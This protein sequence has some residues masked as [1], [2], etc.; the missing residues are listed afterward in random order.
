MDIVLK[1]ENI[2]N[3]VSAEMTLPFSKG[4]YA[5][6]G[7]NGCGKSTIMLAMSLMVKTSSAH[8]L[9]G[10]AV[11][12]NSII[13]IEAD[14]RADKWTYNQKRK[15]L[16]TGKFHKRNGRLQMIASAHFEGFYEGSIF[17]GCRFDDYNLIDTFM[18]D[19]N[20]TRY[21]TDADTF[22]IETLGYILH[23]NK[24]YYNGLKKISDKKTAIAN[25][26][27]GIPYFYEAKGKI[28][29]QYKMSS[30][31]CMLIS[32]IDFLNNVIV[33]NPRRK[34][35][36]L[37]LIDEV[38]LALHPSAIDRLV[39]F[40]QD[41]VKKT[42]SE[43]VI[44]FS[45]HSAELI[46]RIPAKNIYLV[47]NNDGKVDIINP[48]YPN[49]AIR[50]LYVPN[51][52][53]FVLLVE[54][55]LT[56]AIVRKVILANNLSKS[57]LCCILP[58]GGCTQMLKLHHDMV[59]YNTL[60]VGKSIISIYDGD[61]KDSISK[62]EEYKDLPKCFLPIPSV[63]KYLK[64]K[65]VDEPDR[66]FIKQIGDKYFTQR[67]LDDIIADYI[68]DPRTSRVKDNDGKNLYKVI[69]SNLDRI[70]ISE[71]EFIKYLA[72]DIYDYENPQKF[73]ETLKKQLL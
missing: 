41:L 24:S 29:S 35:K 61:V 60:G 56:K 55:E 53:D 51:G 23:N 50:N 1:M 67:S 16:S 49:Y 65:L 11:S 3:I 14:G 62:K 10:D 15:E 72:D 48:C 63:E 66:K 30:G 64:K 9:S 7:E 52:F 25:G 19:E 43:L 17:Y 27:K 21:L 4:L 58:A 69:T 59:T 12:S 70:G 45:T 42:E 40:L 71:E 6:V 47:E 34:D 38:E 31:E 36:L 18:E 37:F 5:I 26:F 28:I 68:N 54:D 73:V 13:E 32:L 44:Y 2:K 57:K 20:Y 33:K 39:L 22:V 8:M 46:H